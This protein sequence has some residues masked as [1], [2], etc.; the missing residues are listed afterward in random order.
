[1]SHSIFEDL[2]AKAWPLRYQGRLHVATLCGGTPA[3]EKTARAWVTAKLK[4][5]RSAAEIEN[6]VLE[7]MAEL[8]ITQDEAIGEV[9]NKRLAGTSA[10]KL[11]GKGLYIEGRQL[12]S[13]LKE[14]ISVTVAAGQLPQRG[15]GKTNKGLLSYFA[16]HVFVVEERLHLHRV[17]VEH[18]RDLTVTGEPVTEPDGTMQKLIHTFRGDAISYEEYVRDVDLD[19]TLETDHQ[20]SRDEWGLAWLHGEN[21]GIGASRSQ[22]FGRYE[23]VAW[24]ELK[25]SQE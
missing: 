10:F 11:D 3:D 8:H 17:P 5:T 20:F 13:A 14:M 2:R 1:M 18:L 19:F 6:L 9:A 7:T 4:D 22:S 15:W 23:I 12:K 21:E 16:E 24:E 25:M